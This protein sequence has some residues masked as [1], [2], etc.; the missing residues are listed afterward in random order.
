ML[1]ALVPS[2]TLAGLVADRGRNPD[3]I[4]LCAYRL[5]Q[6]AEKHET[7]GAT[8]DAIVNYR[9][10]N[11]LLTVLREKH[12]DWNPAIVAHRAEKTAKALKRI[13]SSP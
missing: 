3:R 11:R 7:I 5:V 12:S 1:L 6:K 10:A 9:A 13:S 2:I 4:F 8:H